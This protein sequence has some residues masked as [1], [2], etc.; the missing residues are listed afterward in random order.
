MSGGIENADGIAVDRAILR[1]IEERYVSGFTTYMP[2][3]DVRRLRKSDSDVIVPFPL[4]TSTCRQ[5]TAFALS[6]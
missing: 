4:N 5:P 6:G 2:F 1:I 3:D